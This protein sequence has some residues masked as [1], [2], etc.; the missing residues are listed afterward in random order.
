MNYSSLPATGGVGMH[1]G[2]GSKSRA[3]PVLTQRGSGIG[4]ALNSD[5]HF[6]ENVDSSG[7]DARN[8]GSS[9]QN[10]QKIAMQRRNTNGGGLS[11]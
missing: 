4:I 9:Q 11:T 5:L 6:N 3:G 1:R 10:N 8:S 2:G 7:L